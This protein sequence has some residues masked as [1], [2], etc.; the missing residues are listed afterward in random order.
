M[1]IPKDEHLL[2]NQE[3]FSLISLLLGISI[4]SI[5]AMA[6]TKFVSNQRIGQKRIANQL[7]VLDYYDSFQSAVTESLKQH[8]T[9]E[10]SCSDLTSSLSNVA[11]T[12]QAT[13]SATTE[14]TSSPSHSKHLRA[15]ERC[16]SPKY[17]QNM[18]Y[19]CIEIEKDTGTRKG[20]FLNGE[21]NS[22]AEVFVQILNTTNGDRVDCQDFQD[23]E[24]L[25]TDINDLSTNTSHTLDI[26]YSIYWSSAPKGNPNKRSYYKKEGHTYGY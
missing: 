5:S 17:T 22:F 6:V 11:I 21:D 10:Q 20:S 14:I 8:F 12:D 25:I 4:L 2:R 15:I 26:H 1:M 18:A 7:S 23:G 3:G 9:T 24:Q 19:F 16:K 13:F